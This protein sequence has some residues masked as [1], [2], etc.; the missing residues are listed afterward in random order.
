MAFETYN[1]NADINKI[2]RIE[3]GIFGNNEIKRYSVIK[4]QFGI[5]IPE[6]YEN[7]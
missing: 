6:A 2:E 3:F 5:N 4:D 1:Y 7:N